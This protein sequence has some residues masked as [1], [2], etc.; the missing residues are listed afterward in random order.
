MTRQGGR[1]Y[2][3]KKIWTWRGASVAAIGRAIGALPY[4]KTPSGRSRCSRAV[5]WLTTLQTQGGGEVTQRDWDSDADV[6]VARD[7]AA[8]AESAAQPAG[9]LTS[10]SNLPSRGDFARGYRDSTWPA[11]A[12]E[13]LVRLTVLAAFVFVVNLWADEPGLRTIL[14]LPVV[15]MSARLLLGWWFYIGG[16]GS[17][18]AKQGH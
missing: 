17:M 4:D 13:L 6:S 15:K 2:V 14:S 10:S 16:W 3:E 11:V 5:I 7:E 1:I 8:R 18:L 9:G 12:K